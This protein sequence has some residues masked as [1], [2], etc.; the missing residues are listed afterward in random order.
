M[1][2]VVYNA[3][4]LLLLHDGDIALKRSGHTKLRLDVHHT[5]CIDVAKLFI[6][7]NWRKPIFKFARRIVLRCNDGFAIFVDVAISS[8]VLH[9][10]QSFAKVARIL[11][12]YLNDLATALVYVSPKA[13]Q[14]RTCQ[15][16]LEVT[17]EVE[18]VLHQ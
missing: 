4:F 17:D 15:S 18:Q 13:D 8:I 1:T 7:R 9:G 3:P 5:L 11:E 10:G 12:L 16:F 2:V 6:E 14:L